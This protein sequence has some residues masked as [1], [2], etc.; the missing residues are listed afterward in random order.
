MTQNTSKLLCLGHAISNSSTNMPCLKYLWQQLS[1][2]SFPK[3]TTLM[4][5]DDFVQPS[6]QQF[7]GQL[8]EAAEQIVHSAQLSR[9]MPNDAAWCTV[10]THARM[11][12]SR[13]GMDIIEFQN[14]FMKK[15]G[16]KKVRKNI[17]IGLCINTSHKELFQYLAFKPCVS[18]ILLFTCNIN[19]N[20]SGACRAGLGIG[21]VEANSQRA[22]FQDL[23]LM[24]LQC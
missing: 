14:I 11:Y 23:F 17:S 21:D 9:F 18:S 19:F 2:Y 22:A 4:E 13:W 12:L 20:L 16:K 5:Q 10:H 6:S 8:R 1:N 15:N 24:L 7:K 3:S